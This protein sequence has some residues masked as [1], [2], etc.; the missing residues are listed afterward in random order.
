MR[1]IALLPAFALIAFSAVFASAAEPKAPP[2]KKAAAK[3]APK[4]NAELMGRLLKYVR[5]ENEKGSSMAPSICK[6]LDICDGTSELALQT[7]ISDDRSD[8]EHHIGVPLD[9]K[10]KDVLFWWTRPGKHVVYLTDKTAKLRAAAEDD[11]S[12][13]RLITN[14]KAEP[15]FQVEL[16]RLAKEASEQLPPLEPAA[17]APKK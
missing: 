5:T 11:E 10:S 12:G 15:G 8:G 16:A 4:M 7:A 2:A 6:I 9:P 17:P 1:I 3:P 13:T 14:E